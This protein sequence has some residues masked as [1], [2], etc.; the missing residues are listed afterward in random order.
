MKAAGAD[1]ALLGVLTRTI[2]SM[3][4]SAFRDVLTAAHLTSRNRKGATM[5][6]RQTPW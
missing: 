2:R 4:D 3:S 1:A 5:L 6:L